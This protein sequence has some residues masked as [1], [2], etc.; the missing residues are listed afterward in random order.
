MKS[1]YEV[2]Y[3]FMLG[4]AN[5]LNYYLSMN[6]IRARRQIALLLL[7][8]F[9]LIRVFFSFYHFACHLCH[10]Y[11]VSFSMEDGKFDVPLSPVYL[12]PSY[13]N[14]QFLRDHF[15]NFS[16]INLCIVHANWIEKRWN[17]FLTFYTVFGSLQPNSKYILI[18]SLLVAC[19]RVS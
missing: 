12:M 7:I 17:S 11:V 2:V 10:F 3:S 8:A 4:Y 19:F 18:L 1:Y 16:R 6:V 13:K 14:T 15:H 5:T 9:I